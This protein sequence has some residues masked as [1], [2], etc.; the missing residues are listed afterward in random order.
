VRWQQARPFLPAASFRQH[1]IHR[2]PRDQPRKHPYA[3]PVGQAAAHLN[4]AAHTPKI[5]GL[6]VL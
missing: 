4:L 2:V 5:V 3:Y 6:K 1:F